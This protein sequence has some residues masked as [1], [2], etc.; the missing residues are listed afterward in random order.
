MV[1]SRA[2]KMQYAV[3]YTNGASPDEEFGLEPY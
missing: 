1:T 3:V 2:Y